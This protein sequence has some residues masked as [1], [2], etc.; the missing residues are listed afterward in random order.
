MFI[1]VSSLGAVEPVCDYKEKR[2]NPEIIA[3][4]GQSAAKVDG[5]LLTVD[6]ERA[7]YANLF[8]FYD[9]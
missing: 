1:D 2:N 8:I 3:L 7:W 5:W 9:K 4:T 6:F